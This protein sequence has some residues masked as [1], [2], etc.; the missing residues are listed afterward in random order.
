M[1]SHADWHGLAERRCGCGAAQGT[2]SRMSTLSI[3][4]LGTVKHVA[5]FQ[6]HVHALGLTIPC[7]SELLIGDHSPLR[8]PLSRGGIR[9]G[10]RIAVQPMEGWDGTSDGNP[11][12]HTIQRWKKFGRSGGKLIWGGEA[13][14]GLHQGGAKSK[15][16]VIW[17]HHRGRIAGVGKRGGEEEHPGPGAAGGGLL[18]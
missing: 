12:E 18:L 9:I 16:M 15:Q 14:G 11:S 8:S 2:E 5:R 1:F 4:R 7:D 10:N 6:D 13:G 3:L 17:P